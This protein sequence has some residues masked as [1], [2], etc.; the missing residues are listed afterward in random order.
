[1]ENIESLLKTYENKLYGYFLKHVKIQSVC[2]DFTQDILIKIWIKRESLAKVENIDNYI[3]TMARNHILDHL[4]KAKI[5]HNYRQQLHTE[6]FI[7]RPQALNNIIAADQEKYISR[8][9]NELPPRQKE[10]FELSRLKGLSHDEISEKLNISNKTVRNHLFEAMKYLR[11][12]VNMD[13]IPFIIFL[14][15]CQL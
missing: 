2:K 14:L 8:I 9:L 4:R 7:Q 15:H 5:D 13:A 10:I 12:K 1:M 3:F 11:Q 6:M